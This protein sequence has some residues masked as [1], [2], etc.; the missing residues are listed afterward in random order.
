MIKVLVFGTFDILHKGHDYLL[1]EAKKKGDKLF[2]V[3]ARDKTVK[4]L[5]GKLPLNNERARMQALQK[6]AAVDKVILGNLGNKYLVLDEV[7]PDI[8]CIGYDQK[9]FVDKLRHELSKRQLK[10]KIFRLRA[11]QPEVYKTSIIKNIENG[12]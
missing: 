2:V 1:R 3:L 9:F 10:T 8:I 12:I 6:H 7:R 5:K 11:F 4:K